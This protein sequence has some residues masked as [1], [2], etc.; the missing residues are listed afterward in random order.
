MINLRRAAG[1]TLIEVM[2]AVTVFVAVATTI[3]QT[4]S[5][6]VSTQLALENTTLAS[7]VAENRLV[8]IRLAGLPDEGENTDQAELA[9]RDWRV[10]TKVEKTSFPDTVRVT[11]SVGDIDDK[12]NYNY[13][14]TTI[15]GKQ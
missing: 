5:Q 1:F 11:V 14:L 8:D 7:F 15:M 12:E 9:G 4:T 3:S 10:H 13:S 2:I 6:S